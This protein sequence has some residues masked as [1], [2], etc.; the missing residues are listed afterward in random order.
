MT[1]P[2]AAPGRPRMG[3]RLVA[4]VVGAAL[5]ASVSLATPVAARSGLAGSVHARGAVGRL[6]SH[7]FAD[8]VRRA[9]S[10]EAAL[11]KGA[12]PTPL[13][14]PH[15]TAKPRRAGSTP[16]VARTAVSPTVVLAD[17]LTTS[18]FDGTDEND[19]VSA[20]EPPS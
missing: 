14:L 8:A 4:T 15:P 3:N 6:G 7:T 17:P 12:T 13:S 2:N 11:H 19:L 20:I 9:H 5:V 1:T 18:A 10:P 16:K